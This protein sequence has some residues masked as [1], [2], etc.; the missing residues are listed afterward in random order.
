MRLALTSAA[1]E[2]DQCSHEKLGIDPVL[3]LLA[4][5]FFLK[6]GMHIVEN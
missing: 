1:K 6:Y 5:S 4:P 3:F 2:V